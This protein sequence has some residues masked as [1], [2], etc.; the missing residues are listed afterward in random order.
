MANITG[1][2]ND[3]NL[4]GTQETDSL[5]GLGGNDRI[6]GLNGDDS[7]YGND[8]N[9]F[10]FG[11]NGIDQLYGG[12]GN[13]LLFGGSGNDS[14]FGIEGDDSLYGENGDDFMT[15]S[16]GNDILFGGS[17][18]DRIFLFGSGNDTVFAGEGNDSVFASGFESSDLVNGEG[19]DDFLEVRDR[20]DGG[21]VNNDTLTGGSGA[22]RFAFTTNVRAPFNS[23][24]F[25]VTTITDFQP[26]ID[27]IVLTKDT[28]SL[29]DGINPATFANVSNDAAAIEGLSSAAIVYSTGSGNLFYNQNGLESGLGSG[30][31]FVT[32]L[33]IPALSYTDI[34]V[35]END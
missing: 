2:N 20:G 18:N 33:G 31:Q 22:D 17:G 3:D 8:G 5:E 14:L 7:V 13:D 10:L 21:S 35:A 15:T 29:T 11:N 19:G 6:F 30:G 32:L 27:K 23:S 1:T 9:D 24:N 16:D 4:F 12:T 25:G 34:I 26:G 28:F